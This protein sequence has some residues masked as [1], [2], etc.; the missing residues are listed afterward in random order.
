MASY[1]SPR[2][3][4]EDLCTDRLSKES[5][6]RLFQAYLVAEKNNTDDFW[7]NSQLDHE[8]VVTSETPFVCPST[9]TNLTGLTVIFSIG[10]ILLFI[11]VLFKLYKIYFF[12]I[13]SRLDI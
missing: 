3:L 12:K 7:P 1:F 6:C 4:E 5:Y 9:R 13:N 2:K 11:L 8:F 10:L